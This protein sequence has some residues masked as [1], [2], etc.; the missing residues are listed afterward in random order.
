MDD[1]FAWGLILGDDLV[2]LQAPSRTAI[3]RGLSSDCPGRT[4]N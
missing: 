4:I 2:V 3:S 1:G